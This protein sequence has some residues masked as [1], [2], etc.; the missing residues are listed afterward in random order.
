MILDAPSAHL[1]AHPPISYAPSFCA[2]DAD[3]AAQRTMSLHESWEGWQHTA[4]F[5]KAETHHTHH[6]AKQGRVGNKDQSSQHTAKQSQQSTGE[7][8]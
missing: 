4:S 8:F 6:K 5:V 7:D 1:G 3:C 2:V